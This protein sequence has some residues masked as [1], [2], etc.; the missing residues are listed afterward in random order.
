MSYKKPVCRG[1][2]MLGTACGKCERCLEQKENMN[3]ENNDLR[4]IIE[5]L[6]AQ[7]TILK[8]ELLKL[9]KE[10]PTDAPTRKKAFINHALENLEVIHSQ[11]KVEES[12]CK[13]A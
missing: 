2:F 5:S 11:K 6:T 12:S 13:G 3:K 10:L 1:S 7:N 9:K 8:M 4:L